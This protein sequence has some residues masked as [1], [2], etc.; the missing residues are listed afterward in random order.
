METEKKF[1]Q[2]QRIG[3]QF[4]SERVLK[5]KQDENKGHNKQAGNQDY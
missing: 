2:R 3:Q 5:S 4:R 1:E